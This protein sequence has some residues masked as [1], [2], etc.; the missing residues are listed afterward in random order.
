MHAEVQIAFCLTLAV[1]H[2]IFWFLDDLE[3]STLSNYRLYWNPDDVHRGSSRFKL[4]QDGKLLMI[5][6]LLGIAAW[7]Y[8]FG[9]I[10]A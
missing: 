2:S 6:F 7:V 1:I 5:A 4:L 10:D 8:F 3:G 9:P